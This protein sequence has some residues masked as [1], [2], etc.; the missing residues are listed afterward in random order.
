MK[1]K[2]NH[3]TR[4]A[5]KLL[6]VLLS[7]R[8]ADILIG[9]LH[10]LYTD[11]LR[12]RGR[13]TADLCYLRDMVDICRPFALKRSYRFN[14]VNMH[15]HTLLIQYRNFMRHKS[16]FFINLIGLTAGLAS[17]LLIYLWVN[18]ELRTNKFNVRDARIYQG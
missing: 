12:R 7:E 15:K 9:D 10:E 17:T 2:R 5:D 4:W 3:P 18:D 16:S 11:R 8:A 1:R 6:T 14:S 13:C